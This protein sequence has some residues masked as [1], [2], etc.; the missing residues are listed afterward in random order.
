MKGSKFIDYLKKLPKK[1]QLIIIAGIAVVVIGIIIIVLLSSSS[2]D[3]SKPRV[4]T[5]SKSSL[6]EII[7]INELST[8][9]Y[10]Y[11]ATATKYLD[12]KEKDAKY[13]VA[14]EGIVTAGIDFKEIKID[15][16]ENEKLVTLTLP[17][18]KILD[19]R[20]D[21]GTMEY[22]FTKDKYETEN[23]SQ[24]AYKLCIADLE[25]RTKNEPVLFETAKENAIS[26]VKALFDPWFKTLD[27][28]YKIDIK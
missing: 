3:E 13:Y 20:I 9:D 6:E 16:N 1:T 2:K 4:T 26:S 21:M 12:K 8:V 7:E 14:Y 10:V 24:E 19:Y 28:E 15:I 22:I 23:I 11:N 5:I 27:K 18:V 25:N 17:E